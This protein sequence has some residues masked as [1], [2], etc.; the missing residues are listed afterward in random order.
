MYLEN[1][2][3][4]LEWPELDKMPI[5]ICDWRPR[6]ANM[7]LVNLSLLVRSLQLRIVPIGVLLRAGPCD[8]GTPLADCPLTA[9]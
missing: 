4:I 3:G 7:H 5:E 6:K 8:L 1:F 2:G 9:I